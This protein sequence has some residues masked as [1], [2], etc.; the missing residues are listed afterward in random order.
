[1][2]RI[3]DEENSKWVAYEISKCIAYGDS[4]DIFIAIY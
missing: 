4:T 3:I 1:M 2:R